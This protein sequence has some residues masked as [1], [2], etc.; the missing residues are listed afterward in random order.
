[1]YKVPAISGIG[2][3]ESINAEVEASG[4]SEVD[5]YP[6]GAGD[7]DHP[8][9]PQTGPSKIDATAPQSHTSTKIFRPASPKSDATEQQTGRVLVPP[10]PPIIDGSTANTETNAQSQDANDDVESAVGPPG[11]DEESD[12]IEPEPTQPPANRP[13]RSTDP[14]P[15]GH[16]RR[17]SRTVLNPPPV[18]HQSS[19]RSGRLANRRSTVS[20][21]GDELVSL[22]QVRRK[23]TSALEKSVQSVEESGVIHNDAEKTLQEK[24]VL[25]RVGKSGNKPIRSIAQQSDGSGDDTSPSVAREDGSPTSH[26]KRTTIPPSEQTNLNTSSVID[27]PR[28]S[29]QGLLGMLTQG[30]SGAGVTLIPSRRKKSNTQP[31]FIPGSSQVPRA[32]SPSPSG[33]EN[34]FETAA[35][36]LARKTPTKSTPRSSSHFRRLQDLTSNDIFFSK[37]KAAQREYKNTP[38]VKVQP[39]FDASDD[40]EEDEGSS[41]SSDDRVSDSHIPRDRCAGATTRRKGRGLSSLGD[42]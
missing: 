7:Q 6:H 17:A 34:E 5:T 37:S 16:Q 41:S 8:V 4:R 26:G 40:G 25:E 11:R 14:V 30:T 28:T 42:T 31:L 13:S 15:R 22:S 12:P 24:S 38:S 23:M 29:R 2:D 9:S 39:Q 21:S 35:S 3:R 20:N 36:L 19:R 10:S 1:M 33:S 27:E 18:S 32:P